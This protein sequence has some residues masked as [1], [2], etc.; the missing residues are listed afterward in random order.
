[1]ALDC[2]LLILE[3]LSIDALLNVAKTNK[4]FESMA[5]EVF[6]RKFGQ[7]T[8][9][10]LPNWDILGDA[11][12]GIEKTRILITNSELAENIL[13]IFGYLIEKISVVFEK[14][15]MNNKVKHIARNINKYCSESL[16]HIEMTDACTMD[17]WAQKPFRNVKNVTFKNTLNMPENIDLVEIFP[18]MHRLEL[19]DIQSTNEGLF[20]RKFEHL[21]HI[22]L[23][24]FLETFLAMEN[25]KQLIIKNPQVRIVSLEHA[26]ASFIHFLSENLPN[27][28]VLEIFSEIHDL[29]D[30][31]EIVF[32]NV[33]ILS[34]EYYASKAPTGIF[35]HGVEEFRLEIQSELTE[36]WIQFIKQHQ[37]LEKLY[38]SEPVLDAQI[39]ELA[40]GLPHLIDVSIKCGSDVNPETIIHFIKKNT[41]IK[42]LQLDT[43]E[44]TLRK[45]LISTFEEA[46]FDHQVEIH[47]QGL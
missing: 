42:K 38:L 39:M 40:D 11:E 47:I 2:Q 43:K 33:K 23:K 26:S 30:S 21:E 46:R 8:F 6:R 32:Q 35:F 4:H 22:S 37:N 12:F 20:D 13:K 31:Q 28:E 9:V 3:E 34:M 24:F 15:D 10:F 5:S 44:E 17:V 18:K 36:S 16:V 45:I 41:Q 29:D 14:S 7:K 27:L 19:H 1:M 25:I